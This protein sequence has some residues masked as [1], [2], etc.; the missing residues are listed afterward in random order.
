[1]LYARA[2]SRLA[3]LASPRLAGGLVDRRRLGQGHGPD[4]E[5]SGVAL[6]HPLA[7]R[8][9]ALKRMTVRVSEPVA[10]V[11]MRA[12]RARTAG[13][14]AHPTVAG[15]FM[16]LEATTAA[17]FMTNGTEWR[18]FGISHRAMRARRQART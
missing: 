3:V 17:L 5:V 9:E 13:D 7:R 10:T 16:D 14:W 11:V 1:M 12:W 4:A 6:R 15:P 18:D 2:R 8:C